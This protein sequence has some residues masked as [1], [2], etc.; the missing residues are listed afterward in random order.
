MTN[1]I[2]R[3]ADERGMNPTQLSRR[4]DITYRLVLDYYKAPE[5]HD[6]VKL[7]TLRK[8]AAALGVTVSGLLRNGDER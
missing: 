5:I 7:G 1:N 8:L 2:R 4:A 3:L 6:G